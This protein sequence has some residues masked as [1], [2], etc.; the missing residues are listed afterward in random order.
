MSCIAYDGRQVAADSLATYGN[1]RM[2]GNE[3]KLIV[4]GPR[5]YGMTGLSAMFAPL[6]AWYEDG[7]QVATMPAAPGDAT[8]AFLVWEGGRCFVY[9]PKL[10]YAEEA[11]AP[12]AW[13]CGCDHA[14]GAM[15]A[16]SLAGITDN[17]ARRAVEATIE[18]DVKCGGPVLVYDLAEIAEASIKAKRRG[19]RRSP[20]VVAA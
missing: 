8:F 5:L 1:L 15:K 2:P 17:L 11:F 7:A 16:L 6:M 3:V 4:A 13:G 9:R 10:P 20:M 18:L 12:D 14:L 19:V